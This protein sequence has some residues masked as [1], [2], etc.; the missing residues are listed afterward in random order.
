VSGYLLDTNVVSAFA[1]G[2]PAASPQLVEW[3][4][5]HSDR[6]FLSVISLVEVEAGI[7]KLQRCGAKTRADQLAAWIDQILDAY[8]ERIL[9]FDLAAGRIAGALTDRVRATG[10][11]PGFADVAIAATA[12]RY[13]LVLLTAN[14]RDFRATG[15]RYAN[16]FE[17]LPH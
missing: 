13:D 12:Q 8:N 6:L 1:P 2:R 9:A 15:V 4:E 10:S 5:V 16:P 17:T 11:N 14:V 3:L 7:N